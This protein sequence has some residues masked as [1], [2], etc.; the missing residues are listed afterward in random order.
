[1]MPPLCRASTVT[2]LHPTPLIKR[3]CFA[4]PLNLR[5]LTLGTPSLGLCF[6]GN[7]VYMITYV[8]S[9]NKCE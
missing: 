9:L 2:E 3:Q 6:Q 5:K 7:Q 8:S 4:V 1:M